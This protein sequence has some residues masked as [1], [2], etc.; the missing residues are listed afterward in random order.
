[1]AFSS[2]SSSSP[3]DFVLGVVRLRG[4]SRP[5]VPLVVRQFW[6]SRST[7]TDVVDP[8]R[9]DDESHDAESTIVDTTTLLI[10][11]GAAG[12]VIVGGMAAERE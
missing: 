2:H 1:M 11:A 9:N 6:H 12:H 10:F 7:T 5:I 8:P 3:S 4:I